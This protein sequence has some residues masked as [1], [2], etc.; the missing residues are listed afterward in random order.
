MAYATRIDLVTVGMNAQA[1]GALPQATVDANLQEVGDFSDS[2][3][4]ARWGTAAVPLVAWDSTVTRVNAR[5]CAFHL[6][7]I[8]GLKPGGGDWDLFRSGYDDAVAWLEKVQRQQAHPKVTLAGVNLPGSV[9]PKLN[10][11][12]VVNVATGRQARNRGW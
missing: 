2:F 10:S 5:I 4:R 11:A 3:F 9:Q 8:R 12:S 6:M 7:T 1:L